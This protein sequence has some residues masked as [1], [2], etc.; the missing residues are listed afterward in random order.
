MYRLSYHWFAPL[1]TV[2]VLLVG[3][4]VTW[5]TGATDPS[6]VDRILLSPVIHR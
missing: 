2:V 6:S 4:L 3:G 1:G 5:I